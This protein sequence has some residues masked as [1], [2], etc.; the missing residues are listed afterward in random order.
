MSEVQDQVQVSFS[1]NP[2]QEYISIIDAA[3]RDLAADNAGAHWEPEVINAARELYNSDRPEFYRKR[4]EIKTANKEAQITAWTKAITKDRGESG[5]SSAKADQL[6]AL[7]RESSELFHDDRGNSYVTFEQDKHFETWALGSDGFKKWLSYKAFRE[8]G[9]TPSETAFTAA[10]STLK[11]F[12][13]H[14]GDEQ[15]IYLRCAPIDGGYLIDQTNDDWTAI[16]VTAQGWEITSQPEKKFIRSSTATPLPDPAEGDFSAFWKHVNI[17]DNDR[18]LLVAWLLESW[19]PQ[20]PYAILELCGEQGSAKSTTHTRIR[21]LSDPN[22]VPLRTAPKDTQDI[23]VSAAN[24]H[25]ASF[26]NMSNLSGKMQDALCT[27]STGGGFAARKL[28]S[29]ADESVIEVKRPVIINGISAVATRPDLI[30][31]VIHLD[32]PRIEGHKSADNLDQAFNNELPEI[33]GGLLT[34]FSNTLK[35]LPEIK[36][37]TLPRLADFALLGEAVYRA[38]GINKRFTTLFRENRAVS[39]KRSLESSPIAMAIQEYINP[40]HTEWE[41]TVKQLKSILDKDYHQPG[42]GWP[43]SARGLS[44]ILRRSAPALREIGVGVEFHGH[45]RD[46]SHISLKH[47]FQTEIDH[48][49]DHTVTSTVNSEEKSTDCDDVT[50]VTVDSEKLNNPET[51]MPDQDSESRVVVEI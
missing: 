20:T 48:H 10:L 40:F 34:L 39:L 26:E 11:G 8:L 42:E 18:P 4:N 47:I 41:G 24:N 30:D 1:I 14:E 32:L 9:F 46:G 33:L 28:Y 17:P 31:R 49:N 44:D 43:N 16:R 35:A 27:L 38:M 3:I 51:D 5:E 7:V 2:L 37:T 45:K 21:Q 6:V 15:Q 22:R 12:A 36:V 19:R 25:Q 50:D 29:D 13:I 23:F